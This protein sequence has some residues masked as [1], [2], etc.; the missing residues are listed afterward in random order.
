MVGTEQRQHY[1][2][3]ALSLPLT[4]LPQFPQLQIEIV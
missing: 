1:G 4:M 3:L 2:I